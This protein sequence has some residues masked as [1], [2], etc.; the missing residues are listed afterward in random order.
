MA[1]G[2]RQRPKGHSGDLLGYDPE[3]TAL[4]V[5]LNPAQGGGGSGGRSFSAQCSGLLPLTPEVP[6]VA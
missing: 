3:H 1:P 4:T 2:G 6:G 5:L